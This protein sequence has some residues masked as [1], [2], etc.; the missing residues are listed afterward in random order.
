MK[1]QITIRSI[2]LAAIVSVLSINFVFAD[3][4]TPPP[5]RGG[6]LS[7]NAHWQLIPGSTILNLTSWSSV[8]DTD[9][10]TTLYPNFVPNPQVISSSGVYDFQIP[11]WIDNMPVK[12]MRVQLAWI[13]TPQSP[14]SILSQGPDGVNLVSASIVNA[15]TPITLTSGTYQYFDLIFQ[16]NPDFERLHI[17]LPPQNILTQVMVDT[18]STVPEP[19]TISMLAIGALSLFRRKNV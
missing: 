17:G 19:A 3:D 1:T 7:V 6:P 2:I 12:Y 13:G 8:D 4:L 10:T 9:P 15:S 14:I 5:Y 18:I 16:P 11:N